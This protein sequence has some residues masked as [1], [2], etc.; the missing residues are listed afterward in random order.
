MEKLT[1]CRIKAIRPALPT[2]K[3]RAIME[4][5][6]VCRIRTTRPALVIGNK[7]SNHGETHSL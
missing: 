5:L 3:K 4:K 6:T 7:R 2:G 1:R